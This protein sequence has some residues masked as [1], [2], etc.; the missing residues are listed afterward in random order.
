MGRCVV[1]VPFGIRERQRSSAERESER[2]WLFA[3]ALRGDDDDAID[4][5]D[6]APGSEED[7]HDARAAEV[8]RC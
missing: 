6:A 1:V 7:T 5:H 8:H 2:E 4:D 3:T